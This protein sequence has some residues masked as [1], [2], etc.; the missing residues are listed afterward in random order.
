LCGQEVRVRLTIGHLVVAG[1]HRHT[2]RADTPYWIMGITVRGRVRITSA[3]TEFWGE[4]GTFTVTR[5]GVP[6]DIW[7]PESDGG[8][9]EYYG[10]LSLPPNWPRL[11]ENWSQPVPGCYRIKPENPRRR[12][13]VVESWRRANEDRN[14]GRPASEELALLWLRR[15]LTIA[16]EEA[17]PHLAVYDPRVQAAIE[18]AHARLAEPIRVTDLARAAHLSV[19]C[20][21]HLFAREVGIAPM[22]YVERVRINRAGEL[23]L[24]TGSPVR[25]VGLE[26]GFANPFHFSRRFRAVVG[27]SPQQ[28]RDRR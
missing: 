28:Y 24:A 22:R 4:P 19:S 6:Y 18:F 20:F 26:V 8:Y 21:A 15:A 11:W 1:V 14:S 3:G 13:E 5:P 17:D 2:N 9:E 16:S 10:V 27:M 25:Q 7:V 12:E 23:L